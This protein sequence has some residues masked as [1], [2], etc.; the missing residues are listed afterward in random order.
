MRSFF[1]KKTLEEEDINPARGVR[2]VNNIPLYI[3]LVFA[4]GFVTVVA[5]VGAQRAH[6]HFPIQKEKA[7]KDSTDT[8]VYIEQ[9]LKGQTNGIVPLQAA[10]KVALLPIKNDLS[11]ALPPPLPMDNSFS[12]DPNTD[13]EKMK[14]LREALKAKTR[15]VLNTEKTQQNSFATREGNY[16]DQVLRDIDTEI[17]KQKRLEGIRVP[18]LIVPQK[19]QVKSNN[20]YE[21]FDKTSN[22][23]WLLEEKVA[24]QKNKYT[25]ETGFVIPATLLSGINSDLPGQIIAQISHNVYDTATGKY[26][27]IPQG[28]K[29]I[30]TYS[31]D[32]IFGQ[33]RVLIAWQRIVFPNG[34]TLD[35]GAMP[36]ADA[37]GYAGFEDQV[38]NHYFK[39]FGSAFMMSAI[40]AG[41]SYVKDKYKPKNLSQNATSMQD[42]MDLALAQEFGEVSAKLIEKN[43][44]VSPTLEIRPG[45]EFNVLLTKDLNF[46]HPYE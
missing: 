11:P 6:R 20:N 3:V 26:R 44:N 8:S 36:G 22:N 42:Q 38:N 12:Y 46:E 2:T 13:P 4:I 1:K 7:S 16:S 40:I 33:S 41:T 17:S 25:V 39:I 43:L 30:G 27:L 14:L 5:I 24:A 9:I 45:Y 34:S 21:Q 37:A 29:L 31:S 35:L 28:A 19:G 32:I 15:V 10:K 23:R 18:D